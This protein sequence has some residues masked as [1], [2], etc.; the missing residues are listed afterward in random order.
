MC[1][2]HLPL[3]FSSFTLPWN[4]RCNPVRL[5]FQPIDL[6]DCKDKCSQFPRTR[7]SIKQN[8]LRTVRSAGS[9]VL[10]WGRARDVSTWPAWFLGVVEDCWHSAWSCQSE[11]GACQD[12]SVKL[13]TVCYLIA[14]LYP[15]FREGT[16]EKLTPWAKYN[17]SLQS[18]Q[19]ISPSADL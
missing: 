8:N 15:L 7:K 16:T 10:I 11:V 1:I 18:S 5:P 19:W 4:C 2:S 17:D 12:C 13:E 6:D 14:Q 9:M 3:H